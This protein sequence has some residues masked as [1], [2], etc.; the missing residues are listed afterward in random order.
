MEPA[1]TNPSTELHHLGDSHVDSVTNNTTGRNTLYEGNVQSQEKSHPGDLNGAPRGQ[2]ERG[3]G[4]FSGENITQEVQNVNDENDHAT[5]R[6]SPMEP[7]GTS[8]ST[9]LR[10]LRDSHMDSMTNSLQNIND[11]TSRI[12]TSMESAD[13]TP[14]ASPGETGRY[15]TATIADFNGNISLKNISPRREGEIKNLSQQREEISR[16]SDG[17]ANVVPSST[18][19]DS[20]VGGAPVSAGRSSDG[21]NIAQEVR[22]V[23]EGNVLAYDISGIRK[24]TGR[25]L[26]GSA[27]SADALDQSIDNSS[28][29]NN[30]QEINSNKLQHS[31]Q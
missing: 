22:D 18:N 17:G 31:I 25:G 12:T 23:N 24:S 27:I 13:T 1:G 29:P 3:L 26:D 8:P 10:H 20:Y 28:I 11:E 15:N 7:A 6:K 16:A 30:P 4:D 9:E 21:V 14:S 5:T 19:S 2:A